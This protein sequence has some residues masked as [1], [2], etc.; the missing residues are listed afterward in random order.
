MT[1]T[2]IDRHLLGEKTIVVLDITSYTTGGET[3]TNEVLGLPY[4]SDPYIT[5]CV[6]RGNAVAPLMGAHD[7]TNNKL[8]LHDGA[9]EFAALGTAVVVL[10]LAQPFK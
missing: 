3:I 7:T 10:E 8:I 2:V 4:A 6:R 1:F 5:G 9:G